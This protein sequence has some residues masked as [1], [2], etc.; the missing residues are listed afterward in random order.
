MTTT[1]KRAKKG[2]EIGAN[3]EFYEGGKFIA[4]TDRPKTEGSKPKGTGKEEIAPYKWEVPPE[5][6]RSIFARWKGLWGWDRATGKATRHPT[7][8]PEYWGADVLE[9]AAQW[10][11]RWNNG[12]RW[13]A[14]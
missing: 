14:A 8:N 3:G 5:G 10:A 11:E 9:E 13:A 12:E 7:A 2:G 6:M 1:H 4:T